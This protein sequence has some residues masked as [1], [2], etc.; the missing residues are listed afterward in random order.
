MKTFHYHETH[1]LSGLTIY[2]KADILHGLGASVF[3]IV[4]PIACIIGLLITI[5]AVVSRQIMKN[6]RE[7]E[8]T[9]KRLAKLAFAS[10]VFTIAML[11][12]IIVTYGN[13]YSYQAK[14]YYQSKA[15]VLNIEKI[16]RVNDKTQ[17]D[18]KLR[19]M[20]GIAE[21]KKTEPIVIK[22][23]NRQ[24]LKNKDV[25]ILKTPER[26]FKG[27]EPKDVEAGDIINNGA[28]DDISEA[29]NGFF[30]PL[31]APIVERNNKASMVKVSDLT[32]QQQ[33]KKQ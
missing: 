18:I 25:V 11:I 33:N 1:D 22:T 10:A 5:F 15:K 4:L 20:N 9:V 27:K 29:T 19:F 24:G 32:M 28:E 13:I 16:E 2:E 31:V 14:G 23:T 21:D 17:Y 6:K 26:T 12:L 30:A 7:R 3:L 8:H